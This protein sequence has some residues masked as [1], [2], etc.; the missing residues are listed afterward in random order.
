[1]SP[2]VC[3]EFCREYKVNFFAIQGD[4]CYCTHYYHARST[5]G[6]QCDFACAGDGKQMCGSKYKAS[7][8]SQHLC[9]DSGKRADKA[10]EITLEA[11]QEEN[12][13]ATKALTLSTGLVATMDSWN[14]GIC[15]ASKQN[16][17][18]LKGYWQGQSGELNKLVSAAN[19]QVAEC[20]DAEA[21]LR[22]LSAVIAAGNASGSD[23]SSMERQAKT[24]KTH[25][26]EIGA[27]NGKIETKLKMMAGALAEGKPLAEFG[28]LFRPLVNA[29]I[30]G[31]HSI[32]DL[33][34]L[35]KYEA[36][37][38]DDPSVCGGVCL[39]KI[40]ENECVA[41]NYQHKGGVT[42]CQ[43]L[44]REGL[45]K[46][47]FLFAVPVFEVTKTKLANLTFASIDCY[48]KEAFMK[49]NGRGETKVSVIK[50]IVQE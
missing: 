13:T 23:Y 15:S 29:S 50:Q 18:D 24:M 40:G 19:H 30:P 32:C 31:T 2:D 38:A 43:L 7:I 34:V 26:A 17:C 48:A 39:D 5:Q 27:A 21:V 1:M 14:L 46:P 6:G 20:E 36:L 9:G 12:A 28:T 44:T 35:K 41:F 16:V 25:A 49:D 8:F 3:F 42:T 11:K 10:L 33:K 47:K 37:T 22:N 45:V 4:T